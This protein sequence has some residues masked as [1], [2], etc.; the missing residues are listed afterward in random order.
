MNRLEIKG[1][2]ERRPARSRRLLLLA[3]GILGLVFLVILFGRN[4]NDPESERVVKKSRSVTADDSVTRSPVGDPLTEWTS[5]RGPTITEVHGTVRSSPYSAGIWKM[6]TAAENDLI[7]FRRKLHAAPELPGKE[8]ET[9]K[10]LAEKLEAL[11]LEIRRGLAGTGFT[12]VL[13]GGLPGP[14]VA[15]VSVMSGVAVREKNPVS[16]ASRK[17]AEV[18]GKKTWVSHAAGR[19]VEMTVTYGV[20][21]ILAKHRNAMPGSVK[22]ILQPGGSATAVAGGEV[23]LSD[24]AWG[25]R[26]M[27]VQGVLEQPKIEALFSTRL[28]PE[29]RVGLI[30]LPEERWWTGITHFHIGVTGSGLENCLRPGA[31]GCIDP[32]L[33]ASQLVVSLQSQFYRQVSAKEEIRLTVGAIKGEGGK[34]RLPERVDIE[35]TIRWRNRSDVSAA[36]NFIRR[37]VKGA[38]VSSNASMRVD[39]TEERRAV[40]SNPELVRWIL[41]SARRMLRPGGVVLGGSDPAVDY[42]TVFARRV[43]S[44]LIQLGTH[45]RKLSNH[46]RLGSPDFDVDEE[47]ISVGVHFLS[48]V[49]LDYLLEH[50]PAEKSQ[51]ET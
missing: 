15:V 32:I 51:D 25:S 26:E 11:G 27:I 12:A 1:L 31:A 22:F 2:K 42:F 13:K 6:V 5:P 19:D 29:L 35:G 7:A 28:Q 10:T 45:S 18:D 3:F 50:K 9:S 40:Q 24:E 17:T 33:A 48:N 21:K 46:R 36:E 47:S 23:D 8:V 30:G 14:S 41:P 4:L 43:P 39:F 38:E 34:G 44:V 49:V 37:T 16:Y 20:A